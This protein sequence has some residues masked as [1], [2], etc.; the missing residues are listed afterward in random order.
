MGAFWGYE[1]R[2]IEEYYHVINIYCF[3]FTP[4]PFCFASLPK[5]SVTLSTTKR[6][7]Y[8][9]LPS[10]LLLI[11]FVGKLKMLDL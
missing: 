11:I 8:F 5:K 9:L 6:K 1:I 10:F 2:N 4:N 3:V 7:K